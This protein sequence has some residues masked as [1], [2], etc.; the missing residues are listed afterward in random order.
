M[1]RKAFTTNSLAEQVR[2]LLS[3]NTRSRSSV[4]NGMPACG[5]VQP[6]V[7]VRK[8]SGSRRVPVMGSK[9]RVLVVELRLVEHPAARVIARDHVGEL[10]GYDDEPAAVV[11]QVEDEVGHACVLEP[12]ESVDQLPFGRPYAERLEQH[13]A[14]RTGVGFDRLVMLDR[15]DR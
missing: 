8:M 1:P 13:V 3:T 14:D 10:I 12:R 2:E 9:T 6:I 11:A 15:R 4:G 7:V 5:V